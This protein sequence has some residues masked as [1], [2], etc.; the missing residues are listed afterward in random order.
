MLYFRGAVA[1]TASRLYVMINGVKVLHDGAAEDLTKPFWIQW[2]IDLAKA[3]A[4]MIAKQ[5][6]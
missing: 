5:L 1:N 4:W 2:A 3:D 6:Q